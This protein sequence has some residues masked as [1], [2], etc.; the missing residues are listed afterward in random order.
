MSLLHPFRQDPRPRSPVSK[1]SNHQHQVEGFFPGH[2]DKMAAKT[3]S[4]APLL[5]QMQT[6][7]LLR[8]VNTLQ[9]SV[10]TLQQSVSCILDEDG[11]L[12]MLTDDN[13]KL[14]ASVSQLQHDH[15]I[16]QKDLLVTQQDSG[17]VFPQFPKLPP[18][19]R[20]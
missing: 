2:I 7:D 1:S 4:D 3:N 5:T 17:E 18:E 15:N 19:I 11:K 10:G 6:M 13:N 20:R 16:L 9:Q 8:S 14:K 12:R